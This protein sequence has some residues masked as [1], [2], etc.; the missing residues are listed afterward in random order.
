MYSSANLVEVELVGHV[1]VDERLP[2]AA[3]AVTE[4][5]AGH[6]PILHTGLVD[7]L[8]TVPD[9][10]DDGGVVL[11]VEETFHGDV[12][13]GVDEIRQA[14]VS[15]HTQGVLVGH[16][17]DHAGDAIVGEGDQQ[18]RGS[19]EGGEDVGLRRA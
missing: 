12:V 14:S 16:G 5:H 10:V 6:R 11:A 19:V 18:V 8:N 4:V 13:N 2:D 3:K 1:K 15:L 17:D 7:S 9:D